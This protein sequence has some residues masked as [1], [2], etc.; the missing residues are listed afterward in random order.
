[1]KK[2]SGLLIAMLALLAGCQKSE[3]VALTEVT[4]HIQ[5]ANT[6]AD[7]AIKSS[8]G[9]PVDVLI[10]D[11]S[12]ETVVPI[13]KTGQWPQGNFTSVAVR[14]VDTG[15]RLGSA[16]QRVVFVVTLRQL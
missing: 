12:H 13:N 14:F 2:L 9:L 11:G 6:T 15:K 3:P 4:A 1:M 10:V 7:G 16:R 8:G 5:K